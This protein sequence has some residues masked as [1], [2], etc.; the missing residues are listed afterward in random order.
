MDLS[1]LESIN[2]YLKRMS[3]EIDQNNNLILKLCEL[4]SVH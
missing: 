2:I 3:I 1:L 4:Y